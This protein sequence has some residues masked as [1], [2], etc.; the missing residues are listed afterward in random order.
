MEDKLY[1]LFGNKLPKIDKIKDVMDKCLIP[2]SEDE[3]IK[4]KNQKPQFEDSM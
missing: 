1:V 3:L 4:N 2:Y